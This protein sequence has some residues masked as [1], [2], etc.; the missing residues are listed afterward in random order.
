M[1]DEYVINRAAF[2]DVHCRELQA[3]LTESGEWTLGEV[4]H[5]VEAFRQSEA[6]QH[7]IDF[8]V[9]RCIAMMEGKVH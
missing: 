4:I 1:E 5:A 3:K 7:L 2:E 8:D 9:K 6:M